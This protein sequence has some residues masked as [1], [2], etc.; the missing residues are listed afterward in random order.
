MRP[1]ALPH[2]LFLLCVLSACQDSADEGVS[3]QAEASADQELLA[4]P[5]PDSQQEPPVELLAE[6]ELEESDAV[7]NVTPLVYPDGEGGFLVAD[8][9]EAQVRR[10]SSE[11]ALDWFVG[12]RGDGPLEFRGPTVA[13][14]L[15][16]GR[17]LVVDA[18]SRFVL[19]SS[20]GEEL[21]ATLSY[22][23]GRVEGAAQLVEGEILVGGLQLRAQVADPMVA[24]VSG[25]RLHVLD[26]QG[27]RISRSFFRPFSDLGAEIA[28]LA[29]SVSFAVRSSRIA[30]TAL[31]KDT[32]FLFDL[33]G[34]ELR[35]VPMPSDFF[36]PIQ[37][38]GFADFQDPRK[39][40]SWLESW[41]SVTDI[42]WLSDTELVVQYRSMEGTSQVWHLLG[43]TVDGERLFEWRGSPRLLANLPAD[44]TVLLQSPNA[45]APNKWSIARFTY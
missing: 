30:A 45:M 43:M 29:G 7:I 11:G 15:D 8:I 5:R 20:S 42:E 35:K 16:D 9:R 25:P 40:T 21:L 39:R 23:I 41:D 2:L 44:R 1:V 17:I 3:A 31:P 14:R 38:M 37:P 36:R 22:E 27:D 24:Q 26:I 12:R 19:L 28:A 18:P 10:Y 34:T 6:V 33:E 13:V 4:Q 32:V